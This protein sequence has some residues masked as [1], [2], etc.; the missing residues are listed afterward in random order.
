MS[1]SEFHVPEE[2]I[3]ENVVLSYKMLVTDP[4]GNQG[5]F[6]AAGKLTK[7]FDTSLL[8]RVDQGEICVPKANIHHM[9]KV[10]A[11]A[12]AQNVPPSAQKQ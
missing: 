9:V 2:W 6:N 7:I 12:M 1:A 10:S 11:I 8:V 5:M 3:G 4:N